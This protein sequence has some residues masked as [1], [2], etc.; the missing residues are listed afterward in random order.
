MNKNFAALA[1]PLFPLWPF[2]GFLLSLLNLK[3][4]TSSIVFVLFYAV[5]G[6]SF[7]FEESSADSFRYALVFQVFEF[8]SM[9]DIY[10]LY[11][12][13]GTT[14]I[15]RNFIFGLTKIFT[16]NP[17]VLYAFFGSVFGLFSYLSLR[18]ISEVKGNR[19]DFYFFILILMFY[20]IYPIPAM[21]GARFN[22]AA[23]LFFY[24]SSSFLL[25][26]KISWI[27]GILATPLFHFSFLFII[28]F[29]FLFK[30]FGGFFYSRN[31]ILHWLFVAFII[32][33]I[34]KWF[35]D[36][37]A[38]NIGFFSNSGILS[39][40]VERKINIYNSEQATEIIKQRN[41][42]FHKVSKPFSYL[43]SI[44]FFV[45]LLKA[46]QIIEKIRIR[47]DLHKHLAF[48]YFF[49]TISHL[50]STIPSGG[51]FVAIGYLFVILLMIRFYKF[52]PVNIYR[53]YIILGLPVFAFTISFG[54][55][56]LSISL[57][58]PTLWYGNIFLIISEGMNFIMD[59]SF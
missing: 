45:F 10:T 46:R 33:F 52:L 50:A 37:N 14:D 4:W 48:I 59:F 32:S 25:N 30:F 2:G 38:I 12:A 31:K 3:I 41:S 26:G 6:Y 36:T 9:T 34:L 5:F 18:M 24:S 35:L 8:S 21:N 19:I 15:Y 20:S 1:L 27:W 56:F 49:L 58:S 22:T 13:G 40:S 17:K 43:M 55:V 57:V 29:I 54:L 42:L 23:I 7:A 28:P 44:Y 39:D 16:N 53:E 47:N 11:K 51:R